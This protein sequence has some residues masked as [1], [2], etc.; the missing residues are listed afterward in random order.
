MSDRHLSS[1]PP[2]APRELSPPQTSLWSNLEASAARDPNKACIV[3]YDSVLSY[4]QVKAECERLAGFLQKE[5]GVKR[6]D[7]V[8]LYMQNSPQ[9]VIAYYAILRADAMVVPVNPMNL[10]RRARTYMLQD[11]GATRADRRA[12]ALRR[13]SRRCSV[14]ARSQHVIV[15]AYSDYLTSRDRSRR[16]RLRARAAPAA[17]RARL[18]LWTDAMARRPRAAAAHRRAR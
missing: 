17:Q 9:F 11:S 4:A 8:G 6:G 2:S 18:T 13:R 14:A 10:H 15:A 16:A 5:C 7:R 3:L 12:G 1:W